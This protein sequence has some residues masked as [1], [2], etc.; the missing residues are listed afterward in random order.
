MMEQPHSAL[1]SR[2]GTL[3]P[4]HFPRKNLLSFLLADAKGTILPLGFP[5]KKVYLMNSTSQESNF[6]LQFPQ[7]PN[8]GG[9]EQYPEQYQVQPLG[10]PPLEQR[11]ANGINRGV[12]NFANGITNTRKLIFRVRPKVL[13]WHRLRDGIRLGQG[14][15]DFGVAARDRLYYF[16]KGLVTLRSQ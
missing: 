5:W 12:D 1:L 8:Q 16:G 15:R 11:I 7:Y 4:V 2:W 13:L 9:Y 3:F 14:I 10:R 6:V